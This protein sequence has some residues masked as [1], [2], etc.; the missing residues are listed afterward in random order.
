MKNHLIKTAFAAFAAFAMS[1]S[2]VNVITNGSFENPSYPTGGGAFLLPSSWLGTSPTT[3]YLTVATSN[4][5]ISRSFNGT[6][7]TQYAGIQNNTAQKSLLSTSFNTPSAGNYTLSFDYFGRELDATTLAKSFDVLVDGVKVG[8]TTTVT[9]NAGGTFSLP[10]T[11]ITAGPHTFA[12]EFTTAGIGDMLL[13]DNVVLDFGL[14]VTSPPLVTGN[15]TVIT[16]TPKFNAAPLTVNGTELDLLAGV[17]GLS[18]TPGPEFGNIVA[19]NDGS[20]GTSALNTYAASDANPFSVTYELGAAAGVTPNPNGYSIL[21]LGLLSSAAGDRN[22]L[23]ATIE[24]AYVNAP[25]IFIPLDTQFVSSGTPE[26]DVQGVISNEDLLEGVSHVRINLSNN[27]SDGVIGTLYREFDVFGKTTPAPATISLNVAPPATGS[28]T[29]TTT[30]PRFFS[31]LLT[32][33]GTEIDLLAGVVGTSSVAN[34]AALNDGSAANT[35]V[36]SASDFSITYILGGATPNAI[37]YDISKLALLSSGPAGNNDLN[38][39]IDYAIASDP[40]TFIRL[41]ASFITTGNPAGDIQGVISGQTALNEVAKIRINFINSAGSDTKTQYREF[42]IFGTATPPSN[43]IITRIDSINSAN[44]TASFPATSLV[45]VGRDDFVQLFA[46]SSFTNSTSTVSKMEIYDKNQLVFTDT[47]APFSFL[48]KPSEGSHSYYVKAYN[49][50]GAFSRSRISRVFVTE[51]TPLEWLALYPTLTD[52]SDNGDPDGDGV[53]NQDEFKARS[54]P[55]SAAVTVNTATAPNANFTIAGTTP[56]L[57]LVRAKGGAVPKISNPIITVFSENKKVLIA[58]NDD[59]SSKKAAATAI[60]KATARVS[61]P[62]LN[63]KSKDAAL[64]LRL[65]PGK[66][67]FNVTNKGKIQGTASAEV[68]LVGD[69]SLAPSVVLPAKVIAQLTSQQGNAPAAAVAKID[70]KKISSATDG[71]Q[72]KDLTTKIDKNAYFHAGPTGMSMTATLAGMMVDEGKIRWNSTL[73]EV[74]PELAASM[75]AT[76]KNA[77]FEQLL[78]HR[79]GI[80]AFI[81]PAQIAVLPVTTG[82][83]KEQRLALVSQL[84][85]EA[86]ATTI[87]NYNLS[88]AGYAIAAAMIEKVSGKSYEELLVKKLKIKAIFGYPADLASVKQKSWG[89]IT[90]TNQV[91]EATNT[92]YKYPAYMTPAGLFS[93]TTNGLASFVQIQLKGLQG[94]KTLLKSDTV[95]YIHRPYNGTPTGY[96][97]GWQISNVNGVLTSQHI[98]SVVPYVAQTAIQS[99]RNSAAVAIATTSEAIAVTAVQNATM[100]AING[101]INTNT[102]LIEIPGNVVTTP[103]GTVKNVTVAP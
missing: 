14:A 55:L 38:A 92:T 45:T 59:W 20:I 48:L 52:T 56:Q 19:L 6:A 95:K 26:G 64:L 90:P 75:N 65:S 37:G 66:Y 41:D 18:S 49:S 72:R 81:T 30:T 4:T 80:G 98:G 68:T 53:K 40:T 71:L 44:V 78:A 93:V 99:S 69:Q 102:A 58:T 43:T 79:A 2:A 28:F 57:V 101:A 27:S 88:F 73:A 47:Q 97:L 89:H 23:K 29:A 96:A 32:P 77:T 13:V 60:E 42:D 63:R 24:Y 17:T 91:V 39:T 86:P 51:L 74:F 35:F 67:V 25:T 62:Q 94:K 36:S 84:S 10:S 103:T 22:D 31:T 34:S 100:L 87:G 1:A 85:S 21:R 50:A 12:I 76:T 8:P 11:A 54:N 46:T 9:N 61:L 16:T 33:T 83:P 3:N 70:A 7:G 5:G 15:L 82:T